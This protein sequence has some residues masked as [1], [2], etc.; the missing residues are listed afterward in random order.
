MNIQLAPP[1]PKQHSG[2]SFDAVQFDPRFKKLPSD[3]KG[4]DRTDFMGEH[5]KFSIFTRSG[6]AACWIPSFANDDKQLRLVVAQRVWNYAYKNTGRRFARVPD[7]FVTDLAKLIALSN[8]ATAR[9]ETFSFKTLFMRDSRKAH[10]EAVESVGS[11]AALQIAIA[12]RAWRL[13]W[14]AKTIATEL[15]TGHNTVRQHLLRLRMIARRLGLKD[16]IVRH[17]TTGM[18][19]PYK[20][21]RIMRLRANSIGRYMQLKTSTRW[22]PKPRST[23]DVALFAKLRSGGA[24]LRDIADFTGANVNTV[25]QSLRAA[26]KACLTTS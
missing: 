16:D 11:Y 22:T 1:S 23:Y 26:K 3:T 6:K 24:S 15:G 21:R 18:K 2:L 12:Y 14:D 8:T 5:K 4:I 20:P 7:E 13:R 9:L 17:E 10:R 25:C 19:R